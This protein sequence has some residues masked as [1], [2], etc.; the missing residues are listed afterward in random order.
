M[1]IKV[2]YVVKPDGEKSVRGEVVGTVR[3][4]WRLMYILA[5]KYKH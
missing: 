1:K 3:M 5:G 4:E 2:V